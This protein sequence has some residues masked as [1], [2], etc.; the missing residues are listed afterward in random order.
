[1]SII[2][3][4][5]LAHFSK[6]VLTLI[7]ELVSSLQELCLPNMFKGPTQ[8]FFIIYVFIQ[9]EK[10]SERFRRTLFSDDLSVCRESS[11]LF[12]CSTRIWMTHKDGKMNV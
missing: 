8:H 1:M 11:V 12:G 4:L 5:C 2:N 7:S 9:Q 6:S 3:F 10:P